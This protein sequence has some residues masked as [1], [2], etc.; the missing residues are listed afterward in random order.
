MADPIS[1]ASGLLALTTFAIQST[2]TLYEVIESFRNKARAVRELK[3]ELQALENV[4]QSLQSTLND[5]DQVDLSALKLPLLR[6]GE[7]CQ[8]FAEIIE[9]CTARSSRDKTSFRDWFMLTYRGKDIGSFRNVIG[10]YKS[11]IAI[12]LADVN[13]RYTTVT[14]QLLRQYKEM[15]DNTTSDLQE[16]LQQNDQEL[17]NSSQQGESPSLADLNDPGPLAAE[18]E[19]ASIERCLDVCKRVANHLAQVQ[20]EIVASVTNR[21]DGNKPAATSPRSSPAHIITSEKLN[22][23]KTGISFTISELQLLLQDANH[24]IEKLLHQST[25]AEGLDENDPRIQQ[26]PEDLE[27]IRQ[28]LAICKEATEALTKERV[29]TFGDVNS[30]EDAHQI[31][32]ATLGDLISARRVSAGAR[33]KQWLGQMSD[34]SLQ[35]LSKDNVSSANAATTK[36]PPSKTPD[37]GVHQNRTTDEPDITIHPKFNGRH[38]AGRRLG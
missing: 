23:C 18:E 35:Q 15:I 5:D 27:S 11:T 37:D 29:N 32:V 1:L 30:L 28:C 38:G 6:C 10:A 36:N 22:D 12:A 17:A 9:K 21:V 33:S 16:I 19:R 8:A 4:L 34:A 2:K 3:E 31:V 7:A 13:I 25:P 26:A 24:R 14:T 20:A